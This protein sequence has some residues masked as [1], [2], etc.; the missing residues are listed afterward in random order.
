MRLDSSKFCFVING[1]DEN[2][3]NEC[4]WYIDKLIVPEGFEVEWIAVGGD[5]SESGEYDRTGEWSNA[6]YNIYL[7]QDVFIVNRH[8]LFRLLE[9]FQDSSIGAVSLAGTCSEG[10]VLR[11]DELGKDSIQWHD[12]AVSDGNFLVTK[13]GLSGRGSVQSIVQTGYRVV[14]VD[15][16]KTNAWIFCGLCSDEETKQRMKIVSDLEEEEKEIFFKEYDEVKFLVRRICFGYEEAWNLICQKLRDQIITV[17]LLGAIVFVCIQEPAVVWKKLLKWVREEIRSLLFEGDLLQAESWLKSFNPKWYN[18]QDAILIQLFQI[19]RREVEKE[20]KY[21]IFDFSSNLN[22]VIEHYIRIKLYMHRVE[23]GLP[24]EYQREVYAYCVDNHVSNQ[25]LLHILKTNVFLKE[26]FCN[27]MA[28]LFAEEEGEDS[29]RAHLF[30]QLAE[31]ERKKK[32][33]G[34]DI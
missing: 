30:L 28:V 14:T 2:K 8:L 27:N 18:R 20:E 4:V 21:T 1:S 34:V 6:D 29:M 12:I 23:L 32:R 13:H 25:V 5:I 22:D 16:P 10:D 7:C 11:E 15:M 3:I 24:R 9:V 31:I 26:D 19:F 33:K 17:G